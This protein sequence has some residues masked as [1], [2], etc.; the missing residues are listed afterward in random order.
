VDAYD[1]NAAPY[2]LARLDLTSRLSAAGGLRVNFSD[3]YATEWVPQGRLL[4]DFDGRTLLT[5][6][7]AKGFKT[8]SV[9][10][11][12]LPWLAGDRTLLK[13]ERMWQYEIGLSRDFSGWDAEL[14]LFQAEGSN[15]I[16]RVPNMGPPLYLNSGEFRHQGMELS[17]RR[18]PRHRLGVSCSAAWM[19][20]RDDQTVATPALSGQ[21]GLWLHATPTL[22]FD[23]T[24]DS[25]MDRYGSDAHLNPLPDLLLVSGG[26]TWT[27]PWDLGGVARNRSEL[28]LTVNN[29]TDQDY[30][31]FTDYPMPG[32]IYSVGLR[33]QR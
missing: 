26:M 4:F 10:E 30:H 33:L 3:R 17:L 20:E 13:P 11:Q 6:A 28:F 32:V 1:V 27:T 29:L 8:P 12:Y 9:A 25:E 31:I 22:R 21:L 19:L 7:A 23:L 14:A 24:L 2:L 15:Q 16:Q 5:L 18:D